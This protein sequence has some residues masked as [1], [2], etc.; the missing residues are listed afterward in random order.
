MKKEDAIK[1]GKTLIDLVSKHYGQ[2]LSDKMRKYS[3]VEGHNGSRIAWDEQKRCENEEQYDS[4]WPAFGGDPN[5]YT[6]EDLERK[7]ERLKTA[8]AEFQ[9]WRDAREFLFTRI[10]E[11]SEN[12]K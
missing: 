8:D 1:V 10:L 7:K 12:G 6:S 11:R 4:M 9:K 2:A 5:P 3:A